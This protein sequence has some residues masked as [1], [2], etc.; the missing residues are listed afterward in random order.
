MKV[1]IL[2]PEKLKNNINQNTIWITGTGR[3]GKTIIGKILASFKNTQYF[4]EPDFLPSLLYLSNK[5]NKN[6]FNHLFENYF[7]IDLIK[8]D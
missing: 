1:K 8:M 3:S 5:I 6:Y 2:I 7:Y 4:Y